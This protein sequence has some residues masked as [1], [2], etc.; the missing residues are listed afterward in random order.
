MSA[1]PP[2][3]FAIHAR[4]ESRMLGKVQD[5]VASRMMFQLHCCREPRNRLNFPAVLVSLKLA[6]HVCNVLAEWQRI[7][8]SR[9]G[10]VLAL[11]IVALEG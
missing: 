2:L 1:V 9:V 5:A 4:R 7:W 3:T 10:F 6:R 8:A 11:V